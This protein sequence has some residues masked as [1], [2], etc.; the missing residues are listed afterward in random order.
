MTV[1]TDNELDRQE[2]LSRT[3]HLYSDPKNYRAYISKRSNAKLHRKIRNGEIE[4]TLK[5]L[6]DA[7]GDPRS[8]SR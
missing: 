3:E 7:G 5:D 1:K 2:I 4:I 8:I 6:I